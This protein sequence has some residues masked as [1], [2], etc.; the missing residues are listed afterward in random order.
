MAWSYVHSV[1]D[2][3]KNYE[4]SNNFNVIEADLKPFEIISA[5]EMFMT[6]AV[7]GIQPIKYYRK[8][9]FSNDVTSKL[10]SLLN[11]SIN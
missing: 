5:N 10:L 9:I 11:T 6:N 1:N 3:T 4:F 2:Q 7:Q 8:K